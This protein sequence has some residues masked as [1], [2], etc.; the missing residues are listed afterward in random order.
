MLGYD[1]GVVCARCFYCVVLRP[2]G[3]GLFVWH[4]FVFGLWLG[5]CLC[6]YLFAGFVFGVLV[7]WLLCAWVLVI[8]VWAYLWWI[9]LG[10]D[11]L[12]C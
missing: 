2:V 6:C 5:F 3:C 7:F 8:A 10:G 12:A 9:V 4:G 11:C 1:V